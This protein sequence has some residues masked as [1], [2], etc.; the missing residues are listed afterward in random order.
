MWWTKLTVG[1][2]R[3]ERRK[4][5]TTQTKEAHKF[6]KAKIERTCEAQE[7]AE[8]RTDLKK[9]FFGFLWIRIGKHEEHTI[10]SPI[11]LGL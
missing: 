7:G 4:S 8:A 5:A 3:S 9:I 2:K 10:N 1:S 6:N 11:N